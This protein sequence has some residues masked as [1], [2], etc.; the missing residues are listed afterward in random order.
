LTLLEN[1]ILTV[2]ITFPAYSSRDISREL[3]IGTDTVREYIARLKSKGLLVREGGRRYGSWKVTDVGV[4]L[5]K[6]NFEF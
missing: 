1:K 3:G 5:M 4:Q 2:L 6:G